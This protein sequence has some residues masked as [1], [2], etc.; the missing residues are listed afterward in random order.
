MDV[1]NP[2]RIPAAIT[3]GVINPLITSDT[4][5]FN[6]PHPML[7]V[8][9]SLFISIVVCDIWA[10]IPSTRANPVAILAMNKA[11]NGMSLG[12]IKACPHSKG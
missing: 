10:A 3:P 11:I 6:A 2:K 1:V 5:P 8:E 12:L 4:K 7:F 9:A